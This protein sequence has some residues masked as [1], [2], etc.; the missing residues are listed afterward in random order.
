MENPRL[1]KKALSP[2]CGGPAKGPTR[3]LG[4]VTN[5]GVREE[6]RKRVPTRL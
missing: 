6:D 5:N 1:E 4:F 3:E 2:L